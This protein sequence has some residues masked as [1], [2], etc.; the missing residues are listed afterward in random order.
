MTYQWH[1]YGTNLVNGGNISGATSP[2]LVISPASAADVASGANGYYVTVTGPG[3]LSTNSVTMLPDPG[4]G[5][6]LCLFRQRPGI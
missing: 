4:N 6:D 3:R 1:R 5:D 2:M